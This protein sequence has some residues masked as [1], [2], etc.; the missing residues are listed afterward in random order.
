M[1]SWNCCLKYLPFKESSCE[2][3]ACF[4]NNSLDG[5]SGPGVGA[6]PFPA[7]LAEG[8]VRGFL[9]QKAWKVQ[10]PETLSVE[11]QASSRL[12]R[13][14]PLAYAR[15]ATRLSSGGGSSR[16][17][18]LLLMHFLQRLSSQICLP[19]ARSAELPVCHLRRPSL[20]TTGVITSAF[21]GF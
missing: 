8:L 12:W 2:P 6:L 16:A 15:P 1:L 19:L 14:L 17:S 9:G 18:S 20:F 21:Q 10:R 7:G 3:D 11:F 5:I 4:V 13:T